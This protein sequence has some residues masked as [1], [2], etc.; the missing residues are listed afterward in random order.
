MEQMEQA[1]NPHQLAVMFLSNFINAPQEELD[2]MDITFALSGLI[3]Q[4]VS[5]TVDIIN[6]DKRVLH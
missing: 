1:V 4:V 6:K 3:A 2:K 5:E